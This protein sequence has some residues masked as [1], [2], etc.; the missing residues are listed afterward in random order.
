MGQDYP[1]APGHP[2]R[3]QTP[4]WAG[5]CC[6][7]WVGQPLLDLSLLEQRQEAVEAL[8][9]DQI[10]REELIDVLKGVP[11]LERLLNRIA[12]GTAVPRDVA[13]LKDG[14]ESAARLKSLL[15]GAAGYISALGESAWTRVTPWSP[16]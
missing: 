3:Q 1:L 12:T 6:R 5:G 10:R 4:Q 16:W 15:A 8:L 7:R 9:R 13:S 2:G 14:L 11:D